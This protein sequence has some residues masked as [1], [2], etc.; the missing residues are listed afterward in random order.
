ME[1][2]VLIVLRFLILVVTLLGAFEFIGLFLFPVV[3]LLHLLN[4]LLETDQQRFYL[5]VL[6][7]VVDLVVLEKI[8]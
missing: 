5:L 4:L 2:R 7:V 3:L 1:L 6:R 8:Q